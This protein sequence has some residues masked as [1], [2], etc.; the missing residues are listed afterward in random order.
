MIDWPYYQALLFLILVAIAF[1]RIKK[2]KVSLIAINTDSL[3]L[4]KFL[5]G[6]LIIYADQIEET[7]I[8][9]NDKT[10]IKAAKTSFSVTEIDDVYELIIF[11]YSNKVLTYIE[12]FNNNSEI[13]GPKKRID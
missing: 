10:T 2:R 7:S 1:Y 4:T 13:M 9:L 11:C 3:C 5:I 6:E 12:D 8:F